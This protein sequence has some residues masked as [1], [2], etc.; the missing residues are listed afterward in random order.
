MK[1]TG[2]NNLT[3]RLIGRLVAAVFTAVILAACSDD[4][5]VP[6]IATEDGAGMMSIG[7]RVA[8]PYSSL[9]RAD[10][11]ESTS[12]YEDG[13]ELESTID[14][15]SGSYRV[16]FFDEEK[17]FITEWSHIAE[18]HVIKGIKYWT[19]TF[20]G[21]VPDAL[22]TYN[23]THD[24]FYVM[25]LA[26][27]PDYPER[28]SDYVM[29]G[30]TIEDFVTATWSR[31]EAF[32]NFKRSVEDGRLKP[33]YGLKEIKGKTFEEN[34]T[35]DLGDVNLL[36]AI[37]K[38]EVIVES[39]PEDI[40]VEEAPEVQGMNP[41]G[42]C[43]PLG[44]VGEGNDWTTDYVQDI[45]L[46]FDGNNNHPDAKGNKISMK[47]VETNKWIAYLPEFRNIDNSEYSQIKIKLTHRDFY[48]KFATYDIDGR[49]DDTKRFDI[50]RNDLYRFYVRGDL[51]EI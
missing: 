32:D 49:P 17:K 48:L 26:N 27:W 3:Y 38:V 37:A 7:F 30:R 2:K 44:S 19:Y 22:K 8:A 33:F 18:L 10:E 12:E 9:T 21:K 24:K 45:H 14:F 11:S 51:H 4:S 34:K 31:F 28:H 25:A 20:T 41:K 42:Y 29:T 6:P 43:A 50:R 1:T 16:Y 5:P 40:N 35:C 23:A 15:A 36:R 47:N 13:T 46:P 39:L